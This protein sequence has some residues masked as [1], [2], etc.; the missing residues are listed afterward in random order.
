[1]HQNILSIFDDS[2][3][4]PVDNL[5]LM[6][7]AISLGI[8]AE[9]G[10]PLLTKVF[11]RCCQLLPKQIKVMLKTKGRDAV[12]KVDSLVGILSTSMAKI[13]SF[14]VNAIST[15]SQV[16]DN[17]IVACL[18]YGMIELHDA[19]ICSIFGGCLKMIR[20]LM[21]TM[22]GPKTK[23]QTP[24]CLTPSQVHAMVISHSSF[25]HSLS[26]RKS[27]FNEGAGLEL[28]EQGCCSSLSRQLELIRLLL[29]TVSLDASHVKIDINT[30]TVILSVY[31]ASMDLTD[32]ML[33]R[34]LF[35]YERNSC[36]QD[37]VSLACRISIIIFMLEVISLPFS[38]RYFLMIFAGAT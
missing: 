5:G 17:F 35:L 26:Q 16:I 12:C 3:G 28:D 19:T 37:E 25:H 34:L 22:H 18:K 31:N 4:L 24:R 2:K 38:P 11:L 9:D 10:S 27:V 32:V 29:C 6:N 15:T 36:Y 21:E 1:M 7:L 14:D 33:R 13:E 20:V 8:Q 30:W 23:S